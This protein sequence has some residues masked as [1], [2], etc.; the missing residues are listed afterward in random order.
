MALAGVILADLIK[1]RAT[2]LI[3]VAVFVV[4]A[5][6]RVAAMGRND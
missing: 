2:S 5:A 6:S 1:K 4:A 3:A